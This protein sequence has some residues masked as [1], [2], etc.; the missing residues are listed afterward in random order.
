MI[1]FITSHA[2]ELW[3]AALSLVA[4]IA[5]LFRAEASQTEAAAKAVSEMVEISQELRE[6]IR[7][8][9]EHHQA[10]DEAITLLR[11]RA[12]QIPLL[13]QHVQGLQKEVLRLRQE[14]TRMRQDFDQQLMLKD[15]Q[16]GQLRQQIERIRE[17][18]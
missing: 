4:V 9:E 12:H 14:N 16:I 7:Q 18:T 6:R 2:G 11:R 8:L 10:K 3:I 17:G 13:R 15:E 5:S 1:E